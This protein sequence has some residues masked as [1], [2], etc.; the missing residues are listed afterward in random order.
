MRKFHIRHSAL[1][2]QIFESAPLGRRCIVYSPPGRRAF[3]RGYNDYPPAPGGET[4]IHSTTD[5]EAPPQKK[6]E[7]GRCV[8]A[9]FVLN[10]KL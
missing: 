2:P 5:S 4:K 9:G 3:A 10:A 1:L 7:P 8:L 6:N